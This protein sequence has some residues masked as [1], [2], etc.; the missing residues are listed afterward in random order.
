MIQRGRVGKSC[1][2]ANWR[3]VALRFAERIKRIEIERNNI[4]PR[5]LR[6]P[7]AFDRRMQ[8]RGDIGFA[9]YQTE[10]RFGLLMRVR[11]QQRRD[12]CRTQ[13]DR[14]I[15]SVTGKT[16]RE[17]RIV[18]A[19][20]R[21]QRI[22][23]ELGDIDRFEKMLDSVKRDIVCRRRQLVDSCLESGV[24]L[25]HTLGFAALARKTEYIFGG[26]PQQI[27]G[28]ANRA[29]DGLRNKERTPRFF[30]AFAAARI[31]DLHQPA[32]PVDDQHERNFLR[33]E[34]LRRQFAGATFAF[35]I[36]IERLQDHACTSSLSRDGTAI[37]P[38]RKRA[39][40]NNGFGAGCGAG[41]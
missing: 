7:Y 6:A 3:V 21:P 30:L 40:K 14:G 4:R 26:I 36:R 39:R 29:F 32:F 17:V 9:T 12:H 1:L 11:C 28:N 19:N 18:V 13:A 41:P 27:R 33:L 34:T 8:T 10:R 25:D 22:G 38:S 16:K 15:G 2:F 5:R 37:T 35:V 24:L 31:V 20:F 23:F